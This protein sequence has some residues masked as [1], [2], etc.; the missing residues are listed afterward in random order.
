MDIIFQAHHATV[1][2][3]L[4]ERAERAVRKAG[5]RLP[6][7]DAAVVRFENDGPFRRVELI[8]HAPRQ[9]RFIAT[10]AAAGFTTALSTAVSRLEAQTRQKKRTRKA[11]PVKLAQM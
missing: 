7:V 9:K 10:G 6:R 2:A 11:S 8:L 5:E 4:R 1:P 3:G